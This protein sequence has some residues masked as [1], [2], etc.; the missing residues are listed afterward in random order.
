MSVSSCAT[1]PAPAAR[2]WRPTWA[3]HGADVVGPGHLVGKVACDETIDGQAFE[4]PRQLFLRAVKEAPEILAV[5]PEMR[6]RVRVVRL[7]LRHLE[8][9][10]H[11]SGARI[12][13]GHYYRQ[14]GDMIADPDMEIL[15]RF[16][17]QEAEAL[18]FQDVFGY[19][20]AEA[21]TPQGRLKASTRIN[22]FLAFWLVNL[23]NQGH[24]IDEAAAKREG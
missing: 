23:R 9:D 8:H 21:G 17:R 6:R 5:V 16:H 15:V 1:P 13:L 22:S 20:T 3:R 14:N 2:T 24:R 12:A 10:H 18:T 4:E 19:D 7:V 11:R